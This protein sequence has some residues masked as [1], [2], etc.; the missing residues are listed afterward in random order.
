MSN[1][2]Q[3]PLQ[4]SI[5]RDPIE[6]LIVEYGAWRVLFKTV[7]AL[8]SRVRPPPSPKQESVLSEHIRRDIGLPPEPPSSIIDP[9]F[10]R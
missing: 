6:A 9:R 3:T 2:T 7:R 4:E 5:I 1:V 10:P 8:L